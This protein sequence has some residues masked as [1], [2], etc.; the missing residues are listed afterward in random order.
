[1]ALHDLHTLTII[2]LLW[3]LLL[4]VIYRAFRAISSQRFRLLHGCQSAPK[5]RRLG[6]PFGIDH[7]AILWQAARKNRFLEAVDLD[8][9]S[10]GR[11]TIIQ[12]HLNRRTVMTCE[13]DNI[14]TILSLKS[15]DY[16]I[17]SR[18]RSFGPLVSVGVLVTDGAD[19]A[20][21]RAIT[22]RS[23]GRSQLANFEPLEQTLQ[24]LVSLL[25][26][27]GGTVDLQPLFLRYTLDTA[28]ELQLGQSIHSLRQMAASDEK[29]TRVDEFR[30][31]LRYAEKAV[32]LEEALQQKAK[33][34]SKSSLAS[35]SS[36]ASSRPYVPL[37][38]WL[39]QTTDR[40]RLRSEV[41]TML[42]TGGDTTAS[43]L[44][45]L[46]SMLGR[47]PT[48]WQKLQAEI[49]STLQGRQPTYEELPRLQYLRYCINEAL[50]LMPAIPLVDRVAKRDTVL[51]VGGGPDGQSP[52]LVPQGSQMVCTM[53]SLHHR[54]D[55]FGSDAKEFR[56]DRW[57]THQPGE[58][59]MPFGTGPRGCVGRQWA[60]TVT[61]Y[62]TVR[63]MQL[64]PK[65]EGRDSQPWQEELSA[66]LMS[67][68]GAKVALWA[69]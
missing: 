46:F 66:M 13:P 36:R 67:K 55:Y 11:T 54:V 17:A 44:S 69:A 49:S 22:R 19:W 68:N 41:M 30:E 24:D 40:W 6:L 1:M 34:D 15:D 26:R 12:R 57:A 38:E 61:S 59:F 56:P 65:M 35:E 42:L 3:P 33:R 8:F 43:L 45:N 27:D 31:A 62:V 39:E 52:L 28:S 63:L 20:H 29:P 58:E 50:R 48:V 64:F 32:A 37:Y 51:P 4:Q 21:S 23:F 9:R 47:H 18:K 25:P 16:N 2:A 53:Y 7:L 10:S 5:G 60:L 14:R